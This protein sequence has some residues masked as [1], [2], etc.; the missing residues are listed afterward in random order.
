MSKVESGVHRVD[1]TRSAERPQA[2][3]A[4]YDS[5]METQKIGSLDVSVV[6]LGCNNFGMKLDQTQTTEV[7][8]AAIDAGINYFDNADIY[9]G[10]ESEVL[11]GEALKGRRDQVVVATKFG[12]PRSLP[13][14]TRGGS[15]AWITK[16]VEESLTALQTDRI[17]H[18]Q[19]HMPDTDT[20]IEETLGALDELVR[21]GKVLELGCSNFTSDQLNEAKTTSDD[22][23][24]APFRTCQNHYS[25]LTRNPEAEGVLDACTDTGVGFVPFFPLESGLLTGKYTKGA[26][27]PDNSRLKNWGSRAKQFIDDDRLDT[28]A[29]LAAFATAQGHSVLELA[30][31]WLATNPVVTTVIAGATTPEQVASNVAAAGW[32]LTADERAE[33]D[34]ICGA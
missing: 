27:L 21:Q 3:R 12:H 18:Y 28:V 29:E 32:A 20:P 13:D 33:V 24:L 26:E 23:A 7:V 11:L 10:G 15:P 16:K 6:G 8:T 34:R 19:L 30:M 9:G 2:G 14:G 5:A 1:A 31:S 22:R 17:D 4:F 25:L